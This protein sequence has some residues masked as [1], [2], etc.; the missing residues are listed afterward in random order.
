MN[1]GPYELNTIVTGD[2]RELSEVIPDE[3]VNLIFCDPIYQN[4]EDYRWLAKIA[5]RVLKPGGNL[6]AQSGSVWRYECEAAMRDSNLEPMPLLAEVFPFAH[7][8]V[9]KYK[10]N[11]RWKPYLWFS[12]GNRI[13]DWV[14]TAHIGNRGMGRQNNGRP[15][16][17]IYFEWGDSESC[18]IEYIHAFTNP[19][20]II[21][22]FFCGGGTTCVVAKALGLNYWACEID[23]E[24]ANKARLRVEMTQ[25]PLFI[26]QPEQAEL[27]I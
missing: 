16:S 17:K 13:G 21:V 25:P 15:V 14:F 9:Y 19:N 5:A 2:A 23:P 3:S 11:M 27:G 6:I 7:S 22:D 20:D 4:I 18:Y 24:T 26:M 1:L 10:V 8:P 12:K